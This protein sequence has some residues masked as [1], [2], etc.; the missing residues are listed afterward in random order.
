MAYYSMTKVT[1]CFAMIFI[2]KKS[3]TSWRML[4]YNK[5][6]SGLPSGTHD[7]GD[8]KLSRGKSTGA[9]RVIEEARS[10]LISSWARARHQYRTTVPS[11]THNRQE[12]FWSLSTKG[13]FVVLVSHYRRLCSLLHP[14]IYNQF[15]ENRYSCS[16]TVAKLMRFLPTTSCC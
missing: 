4:G 16:E 12:W 10:P 9:S 13:P 14:F 5:G 6:E 11:P 2:E 15:F 8:T 7:S 3:G 1:R